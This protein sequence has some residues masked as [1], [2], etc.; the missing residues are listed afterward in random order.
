ME[1]FQEACQRYKLAVSYFRTYYNMVEKLLNRANLVKERNLSIISST[2]K[3]KIET[4]V[5]NEKAEMPIQTGC[6]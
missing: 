6:M 1:Y 2:E 3:S 4:E 5:K